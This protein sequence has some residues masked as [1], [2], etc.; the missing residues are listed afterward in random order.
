M[1]TVLALLPLLLL[2][3]C[4]RSQDRALGACKSEIAR[5]LVNPAS[6]EYSDVSLEPVATAAGQRWVVLVK[7]SA[8]T[9]AGSSETTRLRC[10]V[11]ET[12]QVT[13]SRGALRA[14]TRARRRASA[15]RGCCG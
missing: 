15:A 14:L 9:G 13:E 11:D 10:A 5:H 12:F 8:T 4:D 1:K 3:G 6:A 7:V 2:P